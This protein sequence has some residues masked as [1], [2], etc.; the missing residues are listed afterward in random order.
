[1]KLLEL[2]AG[3]GSIGRAFAK[4]GF[5]VISLDIDKASNATHTADILTWDYM[6]YSPGE[7]DVVW[8]SPPCT[9][10][11]RARTTA[12]TPRDLDGADGLV[13]KA[14][15]I[16]AY[17]KP[18]CWAFEN[19]GSGLLPGR[20]VVKDIPVSFVTYCKYAQGDF[21]KYRKLTAIWHNLDWI[22]REVCCKASPCAH[23]ADGRHPVSAQRAPG[24]VG[25]VRRP[26]G[27]DKCSLGVL[28]S[29]PPSLCNEIANV[30][31][32]TLQHPGDN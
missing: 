16:I 30:C 1:M 28:Y 14:L 32:Q 13:A 10:Y 18:R 11:S 25:G 27:S 7:F 24:K 26:T 12:K 21:P 3:T 2:F 22:P 17:F 15:E 29:M 19:V 20:E 31:W 8:A 9:M 23:I 4:L 6:Q 5:E